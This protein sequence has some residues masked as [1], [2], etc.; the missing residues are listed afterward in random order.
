[1]HVISRK[2]LREF[3]AEHPDAEGPLSEW[4]R[5]ASRAEW[6]KFAEVRAYHPAA[7]LVEGFVVFNIAGNKYRLIID[8][9]YEDQVILVRRVLTHKDYDKGHWKVRPVNPDAP[10]G[11]A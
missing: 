8:I 7:D 4:F 3:W 6:R 5:V 1:M 9:Y 2:R 11:K 10:K